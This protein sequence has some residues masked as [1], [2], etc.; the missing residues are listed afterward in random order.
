M[1]FCIFGFGACGSTSET[2]DIVDKQYSKAEDIVINKLNSTLAH[3]TSSISNI[4]NFTIKSKGTV[5]ISDIDITQMA[6]M[7]ST[8]SIQVNELFKSDDLIDDIIDSATDIAIDTSSK[9][10][11]ILTPT[12][13]SITE[14]DTDLVYDIKKK[15]KETI[16]TID[17]IGCTSSILNDTSFDIESEGNVTITAINIKQTA[18]MLSKCYIDVVKDIMSKITVDDTIVD[19]VKK[20]ETTESDSKGLSFDIFSYLIPIAIIILVLIIIF[21]FVNKKYKI[22]G[23]YT[24]T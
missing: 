22:I 21:Y 12:S 19:E 18:N 8:T 14:S 3:S 5:I 16:K 2:K 7:D 10:S 24:K 20:E 9:S 15:F 1:S 6:S 11:G 17:D 4:T 23:N 13:K